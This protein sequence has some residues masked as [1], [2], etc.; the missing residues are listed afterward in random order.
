MQT[1]RQTGGRAAAV[2]WGRRWVSLSPLYQRKDEERCL[3]RPTAAAVS[4]S[5]SSNSSRRRWWWR[6][7]AAIIGK[8]GRN[9][10]FHSRTLLL[11]PGRTWRIGVAAKQKRSGPDDRE[12][13]PVCGAAG[14]A[15]PRHNNGHNNDRI[16]QRGEAEGRRGMSG[17]SSTRP[18]IIVKTA[19]NLGGLIIHHQPSPLFQTVFKCNMVTARLHTKRSRT[20]RISI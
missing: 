5:S 17:F 19:G 11:K 4:R 3:A 9:E 2:V 13:L 14:P 12:R 18:G 6:R 15:L 16:K 10:H 8:A 7:A 1:D 20:W